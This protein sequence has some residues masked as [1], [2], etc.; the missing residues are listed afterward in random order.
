VQAALGVEA[1]DL[2]VEHGLV[3]ADFPAQLGAEGR[4]A[5]IDVVVPTDEPRLALLEEEQRTETVVLQF[6]APVGMIEGGT[7]TVEFER[8]EAAG[9][10]LM[11]QA[12]HPLSSAQRGLPGELCGYSTWLFDGHCRCYGDAMAVAGAAGRILLIEDHR[13]VRT[14]LQMLLELEGYRVE[15]AEN[16]EVGWECLQVSRL[17]G[18]IMLDLCM[19]LMSGIE[20]RRRQLATPRIARI[21]VVVCSA[22]DPIAVPMKELCP[23]GYLRKP[24]QLDMLLSTI[25]AIA[26]PRIG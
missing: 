21:P 15:T 25:R 24:V 22:L 14:T 2:A 1:D 8:G 17:P 23:A 19:P 26:T 4:E 20:F 11:P 12:A 3:N 13:D 6:E 16:G 18:V 5:R 7:D 9:T 10:F